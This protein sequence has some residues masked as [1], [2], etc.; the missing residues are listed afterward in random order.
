ML[1]LQRPLLSIARASKSTLQSHIGPRPITTSLRAMASPPLTAQKCEPCTASLPAMSQDEARQ[2]LSSL[3]GKWSL[4]PQPKTLLSSKATHPDA[5]H[6]TYKF[7]DF[8]SAQTF[9]NRLG[10][11]AEAEGHHPAVMVEWGRVTVWWWSH[12][13]NGVSAIKELHMK[14]S[15][16]DREHLARLYLTASQERLCHGGQD[17]RACTSGG[18]V[19]TAKAKGMRGVLQLDI[20]PTL[21]LK[22]DPNS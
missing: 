11:L 2:M 21:Q 9:A 6:R 15:A 8:T 1:L 5:L 20:V 13:I 22:R 16:A 17:R 12:A 4:S 10:A 18:G 14:R 19:H 7:K 3:P